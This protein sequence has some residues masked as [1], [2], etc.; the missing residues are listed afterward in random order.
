MDVGTHVAGGHGGDH[1]FWESDGKGIAHDGGCDGGAAAA[2]DGED[3]VEFAIVVEVGDGG[4]GEMGDGLDVV[5]SGELGVVDCFVVKAGMRN[6]DKRR[7]GG[8]A[9]NV[10]EKDGDGG[11]RG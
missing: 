1:Q 10:H 6:V 3:G 4:G 7:G 8:G 11:V 5:V 9:A 2:A